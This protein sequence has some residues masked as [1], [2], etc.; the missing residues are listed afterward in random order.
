MKGEKVR[1]GVIISGG[2][3]Y[4]GKI[5]ASEKYVIAADKGVLY[6]KQQGIVPD[7]C[8]GDFDSLGYVPEGASVFPVRKDKTDGEIA[9]DRMAELGITEVDIYCADGGRADHYFANIM[10]LTAFVGTFTRLRLITDGGTL[11][12]CRADV[13]GGEFSADMPINGV[14]SVIP[15]SNS[16]EFAH[17][18]GLSYPLDGVTVER[19][20]TKGVSN[21]AVSQCVGFKL[22]RGEVLVF[23][24]SSIEGV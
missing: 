24:E 16:V 21:Y 8:L 13:N 9:L 12:V 14:V 10:L 1:C 4:S 20:S 7:E 3:P 2:E 15:L 19:G 23:I 11:E 5:E 18:F 6:A 22:I 17:S